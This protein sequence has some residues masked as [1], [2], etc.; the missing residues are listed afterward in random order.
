MHHHEVYHSM[1]SCVLFRRNPDILINP[2]MPPFGWLA[3]FTHTLVSL[4]K[5]WN[6]PSSNYV[7][8]IRLQEAETS[9]SKLFWGPIHIATILQVPRSF[10]QSSN[11]NS[12][13]Q[14]RQG[15]TESPGYTHT[16]VWYLSVE[17][18]H[19]SLMP[20]MLDYEVA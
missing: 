18:E 7:L 20:M 9:R 2:K 8:I 4:H 19:F 16:G 5:F 17:F 12:H 13:Y 15:S 14:E 1:L 11:G 3:N 10:N 6:H